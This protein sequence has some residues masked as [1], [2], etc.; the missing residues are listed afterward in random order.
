MN[1]NT[2]LNNCRL[3]KHNCD[4]KSNEHVY[5]KSKFTYLHKIKINLITN[6]S[7]GVPFTGCIYLNLFDSLEHLMLLTSFV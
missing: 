1:M 7:L 2:K 4:F 6:M 3:N 5:I